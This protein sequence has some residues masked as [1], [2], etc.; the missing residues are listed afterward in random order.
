M[1]LIFRFG[2]IL[3]ETLLLTSGAAV[4]NTTAPRSSQFQLVSLALSCSG[5]ADS[6]DLGIQV[7]TQLLFQACIIALRS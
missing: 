5:R 2:N 7:Q 4:H 6:V 3:G 1:M